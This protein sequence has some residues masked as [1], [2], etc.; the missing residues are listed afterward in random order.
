MTNI[1]KVVA[2]IYNKTG[3]EVPF[4]Y[5]EF[6]EIIIKSID[7]KYTDENC[8]VTLLEVLPK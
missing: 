7:P 2:V 4:T 6:G 3:E 5:G 8:Y 1:I